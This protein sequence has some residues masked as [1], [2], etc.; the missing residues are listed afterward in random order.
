MPTDI[1]AHWLPRSLLSAC[2]AGRAWQGM[3]MSRSDQGLPV[4]SADGR[5]FAVASSALHFNGLAARAE[6]LRA[7]G[8]DRQVLSA[9][10]RLYRY[11][12]DPERAVAHCAEINDDLALELQERSDGMFL[13][14]GV[15][16]MQDPGSAARELERCVDDLGLLGVALGTSIGGS[17][18]EDVQ[19]WGILECA[20]D[21]GAI[22]F[23]H[24]SVVSGYPHA[25]RYYMRN[26]FSNPA[27]TTMA[28]QH[29]AFSGA[30]ERFDGVRIVA[31][32]GGGYSAM[33]AGRMDHAWR[34]RPETSAD[35]GTSPS[36]ML[37]RIWVDTVVFS[38]AALRLLVEVHGAD[39]VLLGTD[40]PADMGLPEPVGF[41]RDAFG[42][43]VETSA[44]VLDGNFDALIATPQ[45]ARVD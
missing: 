24:P 36:E 12:A 39:R 6:V 44:A 25:G 45:A 10:P 13:G 2:Q 7:S 42:A 41:I 14:L 4:A 19:L 1:H 33:A 9:L 11:D 31:A 35:L 27:D 34:V 21:K 38:P 26:I 5:S 28:L 29:L 17:R 30:L 43:D 23:L 8:I 32:H 16:P 22:V 40:F 3:A 37:R 20:R 15:L 18:W